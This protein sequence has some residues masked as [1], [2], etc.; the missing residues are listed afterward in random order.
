MFCVKQQTEMRPL[1]IWFDYISQNSERSKQ[2]C[3]HC[4]R[5]DQISVYG[6]IA[7]MMNG[8][9][10]VLYVTLC[11]VFLEYCRFRI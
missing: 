2:P 9:A 4:G 7:L 1:T 11:N 8:S 10:C 5:V 3:R 6:D